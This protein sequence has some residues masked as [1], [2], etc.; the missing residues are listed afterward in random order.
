MIIA[1]ARRFKVVI[2]GSFFELA[3]QC[4]RRI[5]EFL[6]AESLGQKT[7]AAQSRG[8]VVERRV[9]RGME[10][11]AQPQ[12]AVRRFLVEGRGI[13]VA[14]GG[15]QVDIVRRMDLLV[16]AEQGASGDLQKLRHLFGIE[17]FPAAMALAEAIPVP[18]GAGIEVVVLPIVT[19]KE[20]LAETF[21]VVVGN[22]QRKAHGFLDRVP[23][24][25]VA[26]AR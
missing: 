2:D 17:G 20:F 18:L 8:S 24:R 26:A 12:Q 19:A 11:V 9:H 21:V 25:I 7:G 14:R 13:K 16:R 6:H 5:Y 22:A 15:I 1:V 10:L 3:A 23:A 4:R